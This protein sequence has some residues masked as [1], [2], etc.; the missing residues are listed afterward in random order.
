[1]ADVLPRSKYYVAKGSYTY[2]YKDKPSDGG[3]FADKV[4]YTEKV[5]AYDDEDFVEYLNE[6]MFML[7]KLPSNLLELNYVV[8][9]SDA[10]I[11]K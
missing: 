11:I 7:F 10:V 4:V 2:S 3:C 5:L 8:V 9:D 1:M 6:G